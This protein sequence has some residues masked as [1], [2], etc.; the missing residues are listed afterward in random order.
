MAQKTIYVSEDELTLWE[1]AGVLAS[2][3]RRST[4][5]V[6]HEALRRYLR[7]QALDDARKARENAA[8]AAEERP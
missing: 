7:Q 1:Q 2:R 8:A 4:S 5:W 6:I 3:E